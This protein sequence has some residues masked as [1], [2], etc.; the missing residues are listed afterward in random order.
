MSRIRQNR[1]EVIKMGA[2]AA[3]VG[4]IGAP[5]T[6]FGQ[7]TPAATEGGTLTMYSGQHEELVLAFAD[8]FK[9]A[10]GIT[11]DVRSGSDSELANQILEEGDKTNADLF[12]SEEPTS[13]AHLDGEGVLASI[14]P[15]SL[16]K[17]DERFN[18]ETGNWL[19]YSLRS[20]V[21]FYNPDI[22]AEADLPASVMD[23]VD[24][25]WKGTFAYAPS[26]AFVASTN[27]LLNTIGEDETLGW[28]EG[29][30]ANGENLLKNGAVRDAVEA[31]QYGFGLSN[32][33]Y[34]YI[35]AAEKGGEENLTSRVHWVKGQDVG[36][37][38]L[39][40]GVGILQA[41]Q[42]QDLAQQ[43][44]AW[45][46]DPV[47]GQKLVAEQSPQFPT[48]PGVESTFDLPALSELD[49]PAFDQ[50]SLKDAAKAQELIIEA[51]IV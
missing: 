34:W 19:A 26:G 44:V 36:G 47:G 4:A 12:I 11:V 51:G 5:R 20:R 33:Y 24:D 25:A 9:A 27:Y 49:P 17:G 18:P 23:L 14:D 22:I 13:V 42:K 28:L 10:T 50:G 46:A 32:H 48:A 41:S 15:A 35:L 16:A 6:A 37:L 43:F 30:A 39:G 7:A 8:G 1:R 45:M 31:G 29:I 40:S 38:M 2:A 21:I 3:A